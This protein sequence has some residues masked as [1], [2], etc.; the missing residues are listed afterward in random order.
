MKYDYIIRA[1]LVTLCP[2]HEVLKAVIKVTVFFGIK[3]RAV[4]YVVII[5]SVEPAV[6]I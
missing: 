1:L 5:I 4:C 2:T 6:S 3:Q